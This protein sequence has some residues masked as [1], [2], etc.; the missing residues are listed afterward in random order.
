[1]KR[2][3]KRKRMKNNPRFLERPYTRK[4]IPPMAIRK[5]KAKAQRLA[6][7]IQRMHA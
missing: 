4:G 7:R 5:K 2:R 1:M 3:S 6:R